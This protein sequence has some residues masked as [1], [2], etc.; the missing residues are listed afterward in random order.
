MANMGRYCKA[1][2]IEAFRQ[3][4]RWNEKE[5]TWKRENESAQSSDNPAL[6]TGDYLF[7]QESFT[8]TGGVFLDEK[9]VFDEITDQWI[10]FCK[11]DLQFEVPDYCRSDA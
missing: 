1:Y 8:V 10:E 4:P 9:I 11:N 7:L 5:E 3:Y 2:P 6:N